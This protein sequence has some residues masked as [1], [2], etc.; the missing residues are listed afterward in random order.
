MTTVH[1]VSGLPAS[2]K[3]TLAR[4]LY[5]ALRFNMDDQRLQLGLTHEAWN[6]ETEAIV[7]STMLVAAKVAVVAGRDICL[8][9]THLTPSWPR[10]YRKAFE[11]YDVTFVIHNCTDVGIEECIARDAL[12]GDASVGEDVIRKLAGNHEKAR[13][14]GWRLT[15]Q[16]MNGTKYPKPE[17]YIADRSLSPVVLCDIDGTI[18]LH[19]GNRSP[20]DYTKVSG[21]AINENVAWLVEILGGEHNVVFMSGREDSCRAD[22][23]QWLMDTLGMAFPPELHMRTAGDKR[24]DDVVKGELFDK[25]IRGKYDVRLVLDD[26]DRVVKLWREMG[27]TCLQVNYGDF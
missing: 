18:A 21:D 15:D 2:G 22:T 27:L 24:H 23:E 13:K 6:K 17:P 10:A 4:S 8:D 9:N 20:Y 25:H 1:I 12:R 11:P 14:N 19:E 16:W 26:R 5:P 3:T 7:F